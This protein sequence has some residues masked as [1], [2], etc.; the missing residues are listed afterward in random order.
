MGRE[1]R[2]LLIHNRRCESVRIGELLSR[3]EDTQYQLTTADESDDVEELVLS[4]DF[5]AILLD[6]HWVNTDSQSLLAYAQ[7]NGAMTPIIIMTCKMEDE[8]DHRAVSGGASDYLICGRINPALLERS[9]RYAIDR[10]RSEHKLTQ[11][12]HYDI[13]TGMPNR[14]LFLDR[15]KH[16]LALAA[17]GDGGFTLMYMDLDGFKQVNDS[18]GHAIGD[19]IIKTCSQ[20]LWSCMRKSDSVARIGGDEFTILLEHTDSV[21]DVAHIAEKIIGVV[22]RPYQ[23]ENHH[24]VVGCSIGIATYPE[25]GVNIDELQSNADRAMYQAKKKGNH[26]C[27]YTDELNAE[28]QQRLK[29]ESDLH[30][31]LMS[32]EFVLHYQPKMDIKNRN[33]IGVEALLRWQHPQKG[34]LYPKDFLS[35]ADATGMLIPLGYWVMERACRDLR[36]MNQLGLDVNMSINLSLSQFRDEKLVERFAAMVFVNDISATDIEFEITETEIMENT[37]LI[38]SGMNELQKIGCKFALDNFGTG[39]SSMSHLLHL[40]I[41]TLKIDRELISQITEREDAK[42]LVMVM[43]S[44]GHSLNKCIVAEG[45]ETEQQLALLERS[46]CNV[47]QGDHVYNPAPLNVLLERLLPILPEIQKG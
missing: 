21:S 30:H 13:L 18:F 22:A 40:P 42:T 19:E 17:R 32:E 43:A 26:Y 2:I 20:R 10:K 37:E 9:I 25:S 4:S 14:S 29:L 12:A 16:A 33:V 5:D 34:L 35:V 3:I 7:A 15:L 36:L 8:A 27:F 41:S 23:L 47:I 1:L 46:D 6:Y 39:F 44:L 11:L 45:V 28:V 24:I 31:A 38:S